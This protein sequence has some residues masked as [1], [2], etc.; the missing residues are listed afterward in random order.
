MGQTCMTT[1]NTTWIVAAD[2]SRARVLQVMDRNRLEEVENLLNP[3]GR[4]HGRDLVTDAHPRFSG[5]D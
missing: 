2:A 5:T 4:L 3:E 1:T